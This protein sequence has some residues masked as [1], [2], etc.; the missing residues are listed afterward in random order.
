MVGGAMFS[1]PMVDATADRLKL[2]AGRRTF[3]NYWF[4]HIWE[5]I[6]PL[7]PSM[8]LAAALFGLTTTQLI[9]ATWPLTAAAATSGLLFGLLGLP[10]G[11]DDPATSSRVQA[12]GTLAASIWPVVLVILLSFTLPVDDG[13]RLILSLL[14]TIASMMVFKRIP[15]RD[16]WEVLYKRIPWKTV[17]VI[18]GALMFRRVL[19][20][21]GAV[22]AVS[23][24]MTDLRIPLAVVAF[25]VP[26]IP[27]LLTGLM[28]AAYSVSFP[29]VLPLILPEG[30][31]IEPRWALWMMAGGVLG[32]MSSPI[33][34]CLALTRVYFKAE[35]KAVYR[36]IVPSVLLVIAAAASVLLLA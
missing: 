14:L 2:S 5:P 25:V 19:E 1:A 9:G 21:S 7:Y 36:Y 27:G 10:R 13:I 3:V 35:W 20:N 34:M 29:V 11:N 32:V 15:L 17:A 16:L 30:G 22:V 33:H 8:I 6:F 12:L 4:R 26:F 31:Q 18:V 23:K 24:A 28:A